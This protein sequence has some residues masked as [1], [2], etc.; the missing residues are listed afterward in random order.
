MFRS[1]YANGVIKENGTF[2]RN[3]KTG[4]WKEYNP[5]G[6]VRRI[7]QY[8]NGQEIEDKKVG[9][10]L[11]YLENGQVVKGFDYDKNEKLETKINVPVKYPATA[12]EK[13]V[14]G[15]VK[16]KIKINSNCETEELSILEGLGFG[17]D[18]EA[19]RSVK[20][21]LELVKTYAPEQCEE[22]DTIMPIHFK[23]E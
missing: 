20:R 6:T 4:T 3:K 21:L 16:L 14:E 19:M 23:L 17:C 7:T 22:I 10:W 5:D 13:Q 12:R 18:E 2:A 1:Y 9:V 11:E 8:N 15:V